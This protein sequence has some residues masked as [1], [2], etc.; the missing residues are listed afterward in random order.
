MERT[1]PPHE[2]ALKTLEALRKHA[3][4]NKKT[5]YLREV[6][7]ILNHNSDV[8]SFGQSTQPKINGMGY[9][10]HLS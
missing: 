1:L 2:K 3:A 8:Q 6:K 10:F 7:S 5:I 4:A 9:Q